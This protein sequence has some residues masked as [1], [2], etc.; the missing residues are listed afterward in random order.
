MAN[1]KRI[2]A[3]KHLLGVGQS[4]DKGGQEVFGNLT[5][6]PLAVLKEAYEQVTVPGS[7]TALVCALNGKELFCANLGDSGFLLIRFNDCRMPFVVLQ[8]MPRQ[9][10]FNT[11]YQLARLPSEEQIAEGM[12]GKRFSSGEIA[13]TL[14]HY[15]RSSFCKDLPEDA[16]V[17][18][19]LVQKDDLLILATDGVFDNLFQEEILTIVREFGK[20]KEI[21]PKR[22]A[23][24]VA[25]RAYRKS[26]DLSGNS[27]FSE[28]ARK[29]GEPEYKVIL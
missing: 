27:P 13:N 10:S 5:V 4:S 24:K 8:S 29:N 21:D 7:S 14:F 18:K 11:P 28:E 1:C 2:A 12:R 6:Q 16:R 17:Y 19:G 26:I 3:S 22:V 20:E 23:E 25:E 9:H 15:R